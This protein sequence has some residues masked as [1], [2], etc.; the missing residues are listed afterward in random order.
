MGVTKKVLGSAHAHL[1]LINKMMAN[2]RHFHVRH[3][4][5]GHVAVIA[6]DDLEKMPLDQLAYNGKKVQTVAQPTLAPTSNYSNGRK[7]VFT[8]IL[9]LSMNTIANQERAEKKRPKLVRYVKDSSSLPLSAV[10]DFVASEDSTRKKVEIS[11]TDRGGIPAVTIKAWVKNGKGEHE[12]WSQ[13]A[14]ALQLDEDLLLLYQQ[15]DQ[16]E[17][18]TTK[19][20]Q[21]LF[22]AADPGI[23][24][25]WLILTSDGA[26]DQ[27][28]QNLMTI[29]PLVELMQM[30]DLDG[31]EKWNYCPG[32]SKYNPAERLNSTVK[33]G[34]RGGVFRSGNG[35]KQAMEEV[36]GKAAAHLKRTT[37][38]G[39]PIRTIA[40]H[41]A[42]VGAGRNGDQDRRKWELSIE[43]DELKK[44]SEYR[45]KVGPWR[46]T[47]VQEGVLAGWRESEDLDELMFAEMED[48]LQWAIAHTRHYNIYGVVLTKCAEDDPDK[49]AWCKEH[50][51]RSKD[52]Y[53]E[54]TKAENAVCPN[55]APCDARVCDHDLNKTYMG[56]LLAMDAITP[57]SGRAPRL[58]SICRTE[59]H[60]KKTCPQRQREGAAE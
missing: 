25:P 31:L 22:S 41:R 34:F 11:A 10:Q 24:V 54:R 48:R 37:H 58:C 17:Q 38:G 19:L 13:P 42:G 47:D 8:S 40:H 46:T 16:D 30:L 44:F 15:L 53:A 6:V 36:K 14:S 18:K 51:W 7:L 29:I 20:H 39:E 26:S 52:W 4:R 57:E 27:S 60:N 28:V 55:G 9:V 56:L 33:A 3:E 32:H 5:L 45:S 35:Q 59:G 43:Y 1:E 12:T 49:C 50:P 23:P 21:H 2:I